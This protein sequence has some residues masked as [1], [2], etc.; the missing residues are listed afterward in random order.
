MKENQ[1]GLFQSFTRGGQLS[2]HQCRMLAEHK[3]LYQETYR[4]FRKNSVEEDI[5]HKG[6]LIQ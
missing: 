6:D 3:N 1:K 4:F 5:I 2:V